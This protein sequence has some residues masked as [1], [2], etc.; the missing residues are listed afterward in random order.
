M[1]IVVS[2][3][4]YTRLALTKLFAHMQPISMGVNEWLGIKAYED[5]Y[6]LLAAASG[7]LASLVPACRHARQSPTRKLALLGSRGQMV[8]LNTFGLGP[9]CLLLRTGSVTYLGQAVN[10]WLHHRPQYNNGERLSRRERQTLCASLTG[11]PVLTASARLGISP[12]TFYNCRSRALK[13]L[14]ISSI[15]ALLANP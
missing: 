13:R 9:D 8:F 2:D 11:I 5:D 10:D 14:E 12:K 4:N 3:C 1:L 7:M 6:V 15:R